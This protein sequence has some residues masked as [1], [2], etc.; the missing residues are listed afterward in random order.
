MFKVDSSGKV[1]IDFLFDGGAFKGQVAI[2]SMSGMTE[3]NPQSP[4]FIREAALRAISNSELGYIVIDDHI[5][6]GRFT[7][8][9]GEQ[10]YHRGS[11]QGV[12]TFTMNPGD[13]FFLMLVPNGTV[14]QVLDN[15]NAGGALR[16][17]FSLATANPDDAYHVGQIAD[18]TGDGSAFAWEDLRVDRNTDKDYND[19]ILQVRGAKAKAALMDD[20]VN[21]SKDWRGSDL[22]QALI[23][24]VKA[25][26]TPELPDLD[27]ALSDLI[28]DLDALF[29][30]AD[31]FDEE[32]DTVTEILTNDDTSLEDDLAEADVDDELILATDDLA[33][34]DLTDDVD[35][36]ATDDF[37]DDADDEVI[38]ATDDL[39]ETDV[40]D[41]V[42]LATDDLAEAEVDHEV[43]LATDDLAEADVNDEVILATD[44]TY[45]EDDLSDSDGDETKFK[46]VDEWISND[47]LNPDD[48]AKADLLFRLDNLTQTLKSQA[49]QSEGLNSKPV[50]PALIER[51]ET[52]TLT[53]QNQSPARPISAQT[54]DL[55]SRLEKMVWP[56]VQP[57]PVSLPNFSFPVSRQP[58]VGIIDT[59]FSGNNPDIDYSKI[60]W[61][62]DHVDGDNDPTL[63]PGEGNEHGTH[64]LGIIAAQKDN[65]VGID[66]INPDA[67]IW[68][69]RAVGSG[70]WAESL[71]EFVDAA[72][73]SGQP[74]AVVNL[75]LD[76]TQTNPDGSVTTRYEFTPQER[77]AIEYARQHNVMLVVAAG[78]DGGVMSA[79]GQSSQEFDNIITVGA[80]KR[81]N[82]EVALS[83]AYDRAEYSSY[84]NGLDIM[85]PVGDYELSTVGDSVGTM[86]GTS[87]ATAKVTGAASQ[88]WAANPQ[89]S[90]RQVIEILK[91]TATDL[92]ET[93]F[94]ITTGAG[95]L[96]MAAA[97]QLAKATSG[98]AYDVLAT[99]IPDTWS[100]EGKVTPGERAVNYPIRSENFSGWVMPT[101]GVALR[102]SPR[103]EDRS[104]LAEPYRKTLSFDAWT[105][106]ERVTDYQLG[107]PDELW[108][109]VS[110]TNYW[111]PSA[112]IYGFPGSRPPV[113]APVQSQSTTSV[114]WKA[115]ID[116]E[117]QATKNLL[118]NPI[119][120]YFD[121]ARSPQGTSGKYRVYQNG[122]I[123]WSPQ[124]GAVAIWYD[125][126]RE[127]IDYSS[128]NG[129][130]GW[131]GFPTKREYPW[132]GGM[133]TDFEGGYIFWD[134]Q[135]AKAYRSSTSTPTQPSQPSTNNGQHII[136]AVNK[137]NP[138]QWYY[139]PRDITGDRIN[140]TFC[141]WFAA[142][143]LDQLGVPIPRN[144][145]SAGAYTKPHP[146]YGTNTPYKP[147]GTDQLLGF[148][149]RGGDGMWERVSASEAVSSANNGQVVLACSSDH[150]AVVIPGGSGSNVRIAQAG[151]TNGKNMSVSKGFG[152]ITPTYFRYKGTVKGSV[153]PNT[154]TSYSPPA[155]PGQ[156]RQYI[157]KSGDTL[158][159]IAQRELGNANRWR[160]I[161]KADGSTFT[162]AEARQLRVGQSVYLP[163]SYQTGTGTPVTPKPNPSP[164]QN[165]SA[166]RIIDAINRVNPDSAYY[167]PGY[168][169]EIGSG[170][171]T[172]CNWFIADLLEVLGVPIPR[173]N[174]PMYPPV[175]NRQRRNKP[176][177]ADQLYDFFNSGGGGKWRR[178]NASEA[179]RLANNGRVVIASSRPNF[180]HIAI[181]RPGSS[182]S[183]VRIAQ[184]GAKNGKDMSVTE[185]FGS[186]TPSYFEYLG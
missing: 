67:P 58:L 145:P 51:L 171:L 61:G 149:N 100:G 16:P 131:L 23:E 144:G 151:A 112:Y 20:V 13:E 42:I 111:V 91:K 120:D 46:S 174:Q 172:F 103:H 148:M 135:R 31:I 170:Y 92:A 179:V 39:A 116:A 43:I 97:V 15:P 45:L 93:G 60:T 2:V 6:G 87:V 74:N 108:Y 139:R 9:L 3:I 168:R 81:V 107:T 65:G 147:Y 73:V 96:N 155:T 86:A 122:T 53:L 128:P 125:L 176:L 30:G 154:N 165:I 24:Y 75:S 185:G 156:T 110:G 136:D 66:G 153:S 178:V 10:S 28:S 115:A 118:G 84:G 79:L 29:E 88:I 57:M 150:V 138:D 37:T 44:D 17:L 186:Y 123:H 161:K 64:I 166:Q 173:H 11:Y 5:E 80:A 26:I 18:I 54:F 134:G 82:D 183:N 182:G 27:S 157:I 55:V 143:V 129:S 68:A 48:L 62:R 4:E 1:G 177:Q 8:R 140:E 38:L 14:Q 117:Y 89:L 106:G 142:D 121:A 95:L 130:G 7:G 34:D 105:Y 164:V 180:G 47:W 21:P 49:N 152:S 175:F 12:K 22:G 167:Q 163:V 78:N 101:I 160:E 59:G 63:A 36:L 169:P 98:E 33:T 40:D 126:Q 109:R 184:A 124:H 146:I 132:N 119:G 94:D 71:V 76:L 69:G 133:R 181:V 56:S 102:N 114:D 19:I 52:L 137:V 127:Y 41:E 83:K 85:A 77:A 158:S 99:V 70:K 50:N 104:G 90:Y 159:G 141:N 113:L 32:S 25:Y 162:E 72:K 35:D